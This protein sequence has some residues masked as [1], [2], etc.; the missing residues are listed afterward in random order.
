MRCIHSSHIL[1][2]IPSRHLWSVSIFPH[3]SAYLFS[4]STASF[5][6]QTLLSLM[7]SWCLFLLFLFM[8]LVSP[9]KNHCQG[10]HHAGSLRVLFQ[11]L[12]GFRSYVYVLNKF[13][14][15]FCVWCKLFHFFMQI[16]NFPHVVCQRDC[17]FST[18]YSWGLCWNC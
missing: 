7:M 10:R 14:V 1:D 8:L 6:V 3:S 12:H 11:E 5:A 18:T 13:C 9:R 15:D 17:P 2:V 4:F 16:Y